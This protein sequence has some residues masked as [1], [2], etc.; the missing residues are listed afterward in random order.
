MINCYTKENNKKNSLME[1]ENDNVIGNDDEM[2]YNID[3]DT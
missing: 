1:D 3:L 2:N